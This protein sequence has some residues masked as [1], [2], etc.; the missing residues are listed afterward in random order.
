MLFVRTVGIVGRPDPYV[1]VLHFIMAPFQI[2]DRRDRREVCYIRTYEDMLQSMLC[3][4]WEKVN[5]EM[6]FLELRTLLW[7]VRILNTLETAHLA[8]KKQRFF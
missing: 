8:H 7:E 6:V 5:L 2:N 4:Y 3:N 1:F